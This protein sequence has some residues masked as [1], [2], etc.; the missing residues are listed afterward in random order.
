MSGPERAELPDSAAA[1]GLVEAALDL[2]IPRQPTTPVLA[3]ADVVGEGDARP[4]EG[5]AQIAAGKP[6]RPTER[7]APRDNRGQILERRR[8]YAEGRLARYRIDVGREHM[9]SPKDIVGAIANEAGLES[10]FIG[11]INLFEDYSTVELPADLSNDVLQVLR[12][13]RVRQ[14]ALNIRL[15]NPEEAARERGRPGP[16][17]RGAP[18]KKPFRK[19]G[20]FDRQGGDFKPRKP[21]T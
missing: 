20:G 18:P 16:G 8:D 2:G 5:R 12:R 21:R 6:E 17:G 9:A 4:G 1:Q 13:A 7:P 3:P 10:R 14:Q 15:A 11:Q 19:E